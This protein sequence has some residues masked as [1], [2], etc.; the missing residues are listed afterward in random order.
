[1]HTENNQRTR[2]LAGEELRRFMATLEREPNRTAA[3][4]FKFLLATGVRRNEGLTARFS[5]IDFAQGT[6]RLEQTKSG[7]ARVVS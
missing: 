6:W 3:N 1:M 5:A 7:Y 4:F 2:Y